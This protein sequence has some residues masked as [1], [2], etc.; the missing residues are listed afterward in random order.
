MI[1]E[2]QVTMGTFCPSKFPEY[3]NSLLITASVYLENIELSKHEPCMGKTIFGSSLT[4]RL[5]VWRT[6]F[7][8]PKIPTALYNW[9]MASERSSEITGLLS[10]GWINKSDGNSDLVVSSNI[11]MLSQWCTWGVII[12]LKVRLPVLRTSLSQ[13]EMWSAGTSY[14]P[15]KFNFELN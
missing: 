6:G 15:V 11:I 8:L 10:P 4:I 13:K 3:A 9:I 2:L 12:N 7:S 14:H 5:V 1:F